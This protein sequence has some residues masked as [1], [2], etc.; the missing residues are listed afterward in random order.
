MRRGPSRSARPA[1]ARVPANNRPPVIVAPSSYSGDEGRPIQLDAS[2]VT[3]PCKSMLAYEWRLSDG[4]TEYGEKP[5]HSFPDSLVYSGLLVV[6]DP[7]GNTASQGFSVTTANLAPTVTA[8]PDTTADWGRDVAF[9][10]SA[11]DAS[12]VDQKTLNYTWTFGDGSPSASGGPSVTHAYATPGTYTATIV[13][14]DK[15][16]ACS[17]PDER[18]V[19]VT[20]RDVGLAYNGVT[21][22]TYD[23]PATFSGSLVDEFGQ[24]INAGQVSFTLGDQDLGTV[25]SNSAGKASVTAIVGQTAGSYTATATY[26]GS[27]L[28]EAATGSAAFRVG[29]KATM[30][31]YTG[32]L[33]GG[34]NK[35]ITLSAIVKDASGTPLP[36][37][38]VA[39]VLG[40]QSATATTNANGIAATSIKL[41]QKNG[42]YTVTA[43]YAGTPGKYN[44]DAASATFKLQA[45]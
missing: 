25:G 40:K 44:G 20:K 32:A 12:K 3:S 43:T 11:V 8:G 17:A 42:T 38:E 13:A 26:G 14:C 15:D 2:G 1:S 30:V 37:V 16:G 24:A 10:G 27:A 7:M 23:T 39:F 28:Y 4:T 35:T 9:N 5:Q 34:P 41:A 18:V 6:S 22:G 33:T 29:L 45:K 36:G 21:Q 19:H 31:T